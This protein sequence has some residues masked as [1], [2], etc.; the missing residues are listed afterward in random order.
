LID[1]SA[2]VAAAVEEGLKARQL[3]NPNAERGTDRFFVSDLTQAFGQAA[4]RFFGQDVELVKWT[5]G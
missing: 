3:L 4:G 5:L 2:A 1:S